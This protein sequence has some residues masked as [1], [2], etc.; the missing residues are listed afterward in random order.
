[1]NGSKQR[2][3]E[4]HV[5]AR[6][7]DLKWFESVLMTAEEDL[8]KTPDEYRPAWYKEHISQHRDAS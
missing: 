6:L 8:S 1:M 4:P 2:G 5:A 3:A 7:E